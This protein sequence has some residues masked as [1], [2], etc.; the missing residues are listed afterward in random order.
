MNQLG[1]FSWLGQL[2][3]IILIGLIAIIVVVCIVIMCK[4]EGS[5]IILGGLFAVV[6]CCSGVFCGIELVK[7]LTSTSYVNGSLNVRNQFYQ[8]QFSYNVSSLSL[9]LEDDNI[10]YSTTIDMPKVEG[11]NGNEKEY[12]IT[13]NDYVLEDAHITYSAGAVYMLIP[14]IFYDVNGNIPCSVSLHISVKYL[15]N[16]T[17]LKVWCEGEEDSQY[18]Q[19]YFSDYGFR[20]YIDE[21]I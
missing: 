14:Y 6:I 3:D 19:Q 5:R 10:T 17:I 13:F 16:A 7:D 1:L 4:Y 15:S 21:K 2:G 8:E 11:F 20:L 9:Y 18:I 12:M